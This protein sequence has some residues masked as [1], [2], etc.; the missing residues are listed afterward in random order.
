MLLYAP[1][2]GEA[3]LARD[4]TSAVVRPQRHHPLARPAHPTVVVASYKGGV[5]HD[6]L[7]DA[8]QYRHSARPRRP[9]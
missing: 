9:H 5:A 8:R 2:L 3:I 7:A 1:R 4:L 6:A